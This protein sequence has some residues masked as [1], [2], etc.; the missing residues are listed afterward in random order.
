MIDAGS[1]VL[2]TLRLNVKKHETRWSVIYYTWNTLVFGL[3]HITL[4]W[5]YIFVDS[6]SNS[7]L[8]TKKTMDM[9]LCISSNNNSDYFYGAVI[10]Q[11]IQRWLPYNTICYYGSRLHS[12]H[13]KCT[14]E[15]SFLADLKLDTE[16]VVC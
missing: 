8:A 9:K 13:N 15:V 1:I 6:V 11:P 4:K 12:V 3:K 2:M 16:L 7:S 5:K 10:R 14:V